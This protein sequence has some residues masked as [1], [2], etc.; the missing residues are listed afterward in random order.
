VLV[1]SPDFSWSVGRTYTVLEIFAAGDIAVAPDGIVCRC[2]G[3][4]GFEVL[5]YESYF[6]LLGAKPKQVVFKSNLRG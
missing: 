5:F 4:D 3:S 6:T 1:F 2:K